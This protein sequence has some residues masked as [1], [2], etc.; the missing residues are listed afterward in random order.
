MAFYAVEFRVGPFGPL[1]RRWFSAVGC[2]FASSV[3]TSVSCITSKFNKPMNMGENKSCTTFPRC[4]TRIR[5]FASFHINGINSALLSDAACKSHWGRAREMLI[6]I[7]K[8]QRCHQT[9]LTESAC[10]LL[11]KRQLPKRRKE[12]CVPFIAHCACVFVVSGSPI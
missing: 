12:P 6:S 10:D 5:S 7:S 1:N 2:R 9:A 4:V 8:W 3:T 11:E